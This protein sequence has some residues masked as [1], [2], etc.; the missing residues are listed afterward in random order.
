MLIRVINRGGKL[1]SKN[2]FLSFSLILSIAFGKDKKVEEIRI[3][4]LVKFLKV[5]TSELAPLK[6]N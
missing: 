5:G 2:Y 6:F 3:K 4:K 1:S